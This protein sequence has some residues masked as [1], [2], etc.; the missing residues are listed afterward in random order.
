[1]TLPFDICR[2][3]GCYQNPTTGALEICS[4]RDTC[5]RHTDKAEGAYRVPYTNSM[6]EWTG[7]CHSYIPEEKQC[8]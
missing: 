4:K 7:E 8:T 1:M 5:Q 3:L 2:C 6:Q